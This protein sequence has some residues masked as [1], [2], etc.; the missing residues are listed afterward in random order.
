LN[1]QAQ[2]WLTASFS[3][4]WRSSSEMRPSSSRRARDRAGAHDHAAVHLPELVGVQ[5]FGDLLE[6]LAHV[7]LVA[8][9][10]HARVLLVALEEQHL[11]DAEQLDRVAHA[12]R[13]P[14]QALGAAVARGEMTRQALDEFVHGGRLAPAVQALAQA[15]HGPRQA[16][17]GHRLGHAVLTR[18]ARRCPR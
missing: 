2:A 11:V 7:R 5:P 9:G 15:G 1:R 8:G 12:G 10:D 4:C 14:A 6:R 13:Q 3:G 16:L 17:G 18:W